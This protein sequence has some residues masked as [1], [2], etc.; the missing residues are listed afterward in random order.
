MLSDLEL[1]TESSLL[2]RFKTI[3]VNL[4]LFQMRSHTFHGI[5]LQ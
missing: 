4:I 3:D 1:N 5:D 2:D